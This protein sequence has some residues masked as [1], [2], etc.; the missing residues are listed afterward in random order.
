M[1]GILRKSWREFNDRL[2]LAKCFRGFV[3]P[4]MEYCGVT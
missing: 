4:V 2:L 3:L 1:L